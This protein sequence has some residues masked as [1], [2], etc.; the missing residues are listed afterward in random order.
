MVS[1][2]VGAALDIGEPAKPITA[3]LVLDCM[4]NASP[5][6][7]QQRYGK[8]PDGVCAVVGTCAGGYDPKSNTQGD[9]IYTNTEIQDKGNN[10]QLQYFWEAF[11][12]GALFARLCA[13]IVVLPDH[14]LCPQNFC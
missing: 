1:E 9:I 14:K 11:P 6:S 7:R 2:R 4:G 5:I 13:N 8:K 12:V 10:G 3:K